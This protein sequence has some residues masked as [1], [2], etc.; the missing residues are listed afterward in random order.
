M[1]YYETNGYNEKLK[2]KNEIKRSWKNAG[3][4]KLNC[5]HT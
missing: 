4:M 2:I 5:T 3:I 1:T